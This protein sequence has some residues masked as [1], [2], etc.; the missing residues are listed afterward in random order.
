MPVQC[1]IP[2]G[3]IDD[4]QFRRTDFQVMGAAF[5]IHN[6]LGRLCPESA[7][8][9]QLAVRLS[10]AGRT[11][12]RQ[13]PF[14]VH[15]GT[16]RR[17][18]R[19]DL[20]VDRVPYELKSVAALDST[21]RAQAINYASLLNVR[22]VKLINFG[23]GRVE[24][25]LVA[26][27]PAT[28]DSNVR[29]VDLEWSPLSPG[30]VKLRRSLEIF[31]DDVGLGCSLGLY[32]DYLVHMFGGAE[33]CTQSF[34]LRTSGHRLGV[35]CFCLCA[36]DIAFSVTTHATAS[37]EMAN[38]FRRLVSLTDLDALHWLNVGNTELSLVTVSPQQCSAS[39]PDRNSR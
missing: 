6:D 16:F 35:Q 21:H 30:C 26:R 12:H 14:Q 31:V 25:A 37:S 20:V 38:H 7:Y 32:T 33:A 3:A 28:A 17:E 27:R 13:A 22:L 39:P 24:G 34:E 4:G 18:Y 2:I 23:S 1:D 11:V 9:S 29:V 19:L 10:S 5:E 36:P 8:E 15:H